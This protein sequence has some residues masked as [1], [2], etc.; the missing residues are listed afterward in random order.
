MV[1]ESLLAEEVS[2]WNKPWRLQGKISDFQGSYTN[3]EGGRKLLAR[4]QLSGEEEKEHKFCCYCWLAPAFCQSL[5]SCTDPLSRKFPL[6]SLGTS[7]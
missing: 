4:E 3:H 7:P 1:W 2:R 5:E 6:T